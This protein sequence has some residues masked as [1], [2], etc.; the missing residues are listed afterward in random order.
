[1]QS[2]SKEIYYLGDFNCL[3]LNIFEYVLKVLGLFQ[4]SYKK[5]MVSFEL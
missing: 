3:S 4:Q 5:K 2:S 1:M